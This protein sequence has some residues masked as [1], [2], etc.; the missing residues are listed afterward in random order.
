MDNLKKYKD[1]MV[2]RD[3]W[4][5]SILKCEERRVSFE[6]LEFSRK[7]KEVFSFRVFGFGITVT[8]R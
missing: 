2:N 5:G 8:F 7:V 3:M 6:N 1:D 4:L